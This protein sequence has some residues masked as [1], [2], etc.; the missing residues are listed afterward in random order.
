MM[1][2]ETREYFDQKIKEVAYQVNQSTKKEN[3]GLIIGLRKDFE[4]LKERVD[5]IYHNLHEGYV[6]KE[7][8]TPVRNLVYGLVSIILMG[9]VGALIGLVII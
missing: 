7:E 4:Y 6:K 2:K 1:D 9:V 5:D 8:F 3:S